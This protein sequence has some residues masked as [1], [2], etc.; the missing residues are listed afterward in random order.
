MDNLTVQ[1]QR[2]RMPDLAV[3]NDTEVVDIR[4]AQGV[5]AVDTRHAGRA[6]TRLARTVV[7]ASGYD[8]FGGWLAPDFVSTALP[9]GPH[10][11]SI[12]GHRHCVPRVVRGVT[13]WLFLE[14]RNDYLTGLTAYELVDLPIPDDFEAALA[15][16][17]VLE[18]S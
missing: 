7:N 18:L 6:A 17:C 8:G 1:G 10:S 14:Q 9:A 16:P 4:P 15:G 13:G 11:T 2:T 5:I 3:E 12:S